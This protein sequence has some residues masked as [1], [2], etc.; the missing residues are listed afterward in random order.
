MNENEIAKIVLHKAFAL[1]TELGPGLL[2]SVY[3]VL[4][5]HR[6][7][8]AGLHVERQVPIPIRYHGVTFDEGFRADLF[9]EDLVIV[10]LN[11]SKLCFAF[12]AN[13]FLPN[14]V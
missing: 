8:E 5:A 14:C 7:R 2:E 1:H 10:E 9:V 12:T 4:L 6:L 13:N 3:E 11:P